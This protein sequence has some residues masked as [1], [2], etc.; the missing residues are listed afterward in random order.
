MLSEKVQRALRREYEI[1]YWRLVNMKA[2]SRKLDREIQRLK[3]LR[4]AWEVI[5]REAPERLLDDEDMS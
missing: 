3:N 5:A 4:D 2:E 1:Q